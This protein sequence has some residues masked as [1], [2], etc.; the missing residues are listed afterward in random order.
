M[1]AA[2]PIIKLA[3]EK[4]L[5]T[6]EQVDQCREMLRKGKKIGFETTM[7]ELLVK[8]GFLLE[9]Q[10]EEL[11]HISQLGNGT[12]TLF[13]YYRLGKLIGE[14]GM[15]KVYEAS[16]EFMGR[17]VAIKVI[18]QEYTSDK[19]K[20]LRFFQEI[21]ALIKL[22]HPNIVTIF[23]AGRVHRSYYYAMELLPGPSLKDYIDQKKALPEKEALSIIR[24]MALALGH[25]H[26]N[27]LVHRDVKPENIMFDSHKVPKLMDFGVAMHH[28]EQHMTLTQEG[29]T[30]GS[31]HY[32]PPE[33]VDG[34]R[35]IDC[36]ADI[37]S[38]GATLYYALTGSTVYTGDSP[39]ALLAKHLTGAF[40]SPRKLNKL[41]SR[42]TTAIVKKMMAV[43]RDKRFQS[44]DLVIAAIDKPLLAYRIRFIAIISLGV[45]CALMLGAV[46]QKFGFFLP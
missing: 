44:M 9:E 41:V 22:D 19:V 2:S 16:H 36:R 42:R 11:R 26:A 10:V 33:Q 34:T 1:N 12:G 30:I 18:H 24:V 15:G 37:Y 39:Q 43:N 32:T 46:L 17:S 5:V 31:L 35:D 25:A 40:V 29:V 27:S 45:L 14:G 8:Q 38:L 3:L 21:R 4:K 6:E 7:E 13:G 28:D 23:D 20:A